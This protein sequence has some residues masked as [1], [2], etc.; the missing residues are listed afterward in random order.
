V[1][2][3]ASTLPRPPATLRGSDDTA[4]WQTRT[5]ELDDAFVLEG[6][7]SL[8]QLRIA[9]TTAGRLS[10]ARDNAVWVFHALTGSSRVQEW[11]SGLAG[12][13]R[14]LDPERDFIVCA[15]MLGSCYGTSSPASIDP[16]TGQRY[17]RRFPAITMR[18]IVAAHRVLLMH[19]GV[20]RVRL[21]I[22]GSMGGQQAL[23]WAC[24]EPDRF[25]NLVLLATNARHSPWGIACNEAQRM[26][27]EA[28]ST[29]GGD[30]CRDGLAG[31]EAARAIAML[32]YR[33]Y[34]AFRSTQSDPLPLC[35]GFAASGYLRHQ[36]RKLANRFD[37][38]SY[39]TLTKAMDSHDV[40]RGRGSA[41]AALARIRSRVLVA[42]I[43]SD[44]LF[45]PA[46]QEAIARAIPGA[47]MALIDSTYGHD[48]FLVESAAIEACARGFLR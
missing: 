15:N 35:D 30:A 39:W 28:D 14:L 8:R 43:R 27:L 32:T 40:G 22:G 12:P 11:W 4:A 41:A 33:G 20:E 38:W 6:G 44:I 42:G 34:E 47:R 7:G 19:L 2:A 46:E 48:G 45:P 17:G 31:L 16:A 1:N 13:G 3:E 5:L 23:E 18:D 36:G 37:P 25:D 9:Y 10:P 21:G 24:A 26:A 29:L